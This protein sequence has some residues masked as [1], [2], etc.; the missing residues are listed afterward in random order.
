[1]NKEENNMKYKKIGN[2]AGKI[3]NNS[4]D[5]NLLINNYK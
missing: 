3:T 4:F 5:L 1:M 2:V